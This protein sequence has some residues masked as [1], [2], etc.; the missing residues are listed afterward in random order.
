MEKKLPPWLWMFNEAAGCL[1]NYKI[2][3]IKNP[4]SF[5]KQIFKGLLFK[6]MSVGQTDIYNLQ[7]AQ[8][9]FNMIFQRLD[10]KK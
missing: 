6:I 2:Q 1:I 3:F 8:V 9:E 10:F 4:F 5:E 7:C